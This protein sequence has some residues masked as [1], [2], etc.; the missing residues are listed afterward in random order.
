MP[1]RDLLRGLRKITERSEDAI[2]GAASALPPPLASTIRAVIDSVDRAPPWSI[3]ERPSVQALAAASALARGEIVSVQAV[4]QFA[5]TLASAW[6]H[7]GATGPEQDIVSETLVANALRLSRV[8]GASGADAA[9]G[10]LLA[11]RASPAI[12]RVPGL[13]V[14]RS[15]ERQ[16]QVDLR[17][18]AFLVWLLA[19]RADSQEGEQ[20]LLGLAAVLAESLRPDLAKALANRP[21][22][23]RR[24]DDYARHL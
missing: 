16:A 4:E 18:A 10:L 17:L 15:A 13:P 19:D 23:A 5:R 7:L 2:R 8:R 3:E 11:L 20:R 6:Q 24:L 14:R 21:T 9:A 1:L 12:G 22:L